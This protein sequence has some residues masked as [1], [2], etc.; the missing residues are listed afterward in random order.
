MNNKFKKF[1]SICLSI[2]FVFGSLPMADIGLENLFSV[3]SEAAYRIEINDKMYNGFAYRIY[4]DSEDG[5]EYV[6]ILKYMGKEENVVVPDEIDGLPVEYLDENCLSPKKGYAPSGNAYDNP[7]NVNIKTV[8]LPDNLKRIPTECFYNCTNLTNVKLPK[9]LEEIGYSA[10]GGTS[11]RYLDL[12]KCRF[13]NTIQGSAFIKT[14]MKNLDIPDTEGDLYLYYEAFYKSSLE[15]ITVKADNVYVGNKA[16]SQCETL[17]EL[18]F[19]KSVAEFS[20]SAFYTGCKPERVI[21]KSDFPEN[22]YQYMTSQGYS[23]IKDSETGIVTFTF[24]EPLV[25]DSFKYYVSDGNAVITDYFGTDIEVLIPE[26]LDSL[27]VTEIESFKNQ[28]V[29]KVI[30]PSSVEILHMGAFQNCTSLESVEFK[31]KPQKIYGFCFG[32][33]TSLKSIELPDSIT[34]IYDETF[35]GCNSLERITAPGVETVGKA[36]FYDCTSLREAIFTEKLKTVKERAFSGVTT[37]ETLGTSGKSIK[38]LG[39]EAFKLT[40]LTSFEF[41]PELAEIPQSCFESSALENVT[42]AEGLLEIDPYAFRGCINLENLKLPDSLVKIH[43]AAF[44]NCTSLKGKLVL[45]ENLVR[46]WEKAF[47]NCQFTELEF[48]SRRCIVG[49]TSYS[50][51]AFSGLDTL[52]KVTVGKNV[53]LIPGSFISGKQTVKTVEILSDKLTEIGGGAFASCKALEAIELPDTVEIIGEQ[54]FYYCVLIETLTIPPKV[55]TLNKNVFEGCN[56]LKTLYFNATNCTFEGLEKSKTSTSSE[57][58]Y[59]SPFRDTKIE[60][61]VIGNTVDRIPDWCFAHSDK[62]NKIIVPNSVTEIGYGAFMCTTAEKLTLSNKLVIISEKAFREANIP[63]IKLPESLRMIEDYAFQKCDTLVNLYIPDSVVDIGEYAF[64]SCDNLA[65]VRMSDNV[66]VIPY[67]AF[68]SCKNLV[69]FTWNADVKLISENAFISCEKL[70]SFD[71]TGVEKLYESSF[72]KTGVTFVA[73]GENKNEEPSG[74]ASIE[75]QSFK[76]C[77]NLETLSVGGNIEVIKSEAFANCGNLETAVISP[78]VTS[79]ASDAFSGCDSLTIYCVENSYAHKYALNNGI[80]VS[81]FIIA[82]IPN[83]VYTGKEIEPEVNVKVSNENLTENTDFTLK[84]SENINVGTAKV[85]VSGK[86]IYKVLASTANFTIVTKDLESVVVT[87]VFAG[88][89][90]EFELVVKNGTQAL[91]EGVDYSVTYTENKETD[92][93]TAEIT[94]IGNYSGKT[95]VTFQP[96]EATVWQKIVSFFQMIW[97]AIVNFFKSIF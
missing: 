74:L 78:A 45:G 21:F 15:K 82:P 72:Y 71:F 8:V 7:D 56:N 11:I 44:Y 73:L 18:V 28:N 37:L 10:F 4:D 65:V 84:Y 58:T 14:P 13:L 23:C 38:S 67:R 96:E 77:E 17:E 9:K 39:E 2:M 60:K 31:G 52:E 68:R 5:H 87:P 81:T 50:F 34:E 83:Q 85:L 29:K 32:H 16:F 59:I 30:I 25:T 55:K 40:G 51:H 27:K 49:P 46:V 20:E 35:Y 41:S 76:E 90:T 26:T 12:S 79:I 97:D 42:F 48:N 53:E 69:E 54:A 19:E 36:V 1:L 94:G 88:G 63:N 93:V 66:N 43:D 95:T 6:Y 57:T 70:S 47:H 86:G 24:V 64:D 89:K 80:P 92:T 33:C 22:V 62:F 91:K 61:L 3:T 75:Q